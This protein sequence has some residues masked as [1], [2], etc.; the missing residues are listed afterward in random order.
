M[1]FVPRQVPV[2]FTRATHRH[3]S[4]LL[5]TRHLG[6]Y[7]ANYTDFVRLLF[8]SLFLR[9]IMIFLSGPSGLNQ[10]IMSIKC[11]VRMKCLSY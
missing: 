3:R 10:L 7:D 9:P 1:M 6:S 5:I 2:T 8:S 11:S 4:P